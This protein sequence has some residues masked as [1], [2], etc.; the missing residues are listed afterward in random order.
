MRTRRFLFMLTVIALVLA[1]VIPMSGS[2]DRGLPKETPIPIMATQTPTPVVATPTPVSG[3]LERLGYN[4]VPDSQEMEGF[5]REFLDVVDE[6]DTLAANVPLSPGQLSHVKSSLEEARKGIRELTAEQLYMMQSSFEASDVDIQ[7]VKAG[8]EYTKLRVL[9]LAKESGEKDQFPTTSSP[10]SEGSGEKGQ[11]SGP[12]LSSFT[13][14]PT[15]TPVCTPTPPAIPHKN[16][17]QTNAAA[18]DLFPPNW[19]TDIGCP[20]GGYPT[21]VMFGFMIALDALNVGSIILEAMCTEKTIVVG[22]NVQDPIQ[23]VIKS[24]LDYVILAVQTVND[25]FDLCNGMVD[26]ATIQAL[27]EDTKIVHADLAMH[28]GNLHTRFNWTDKFLFNFRN[29]N[30]RL[31]IEANL[32]SPDDEPHALLALPRS[33]CIS[34]ELETLQATDPYAPEV[35]AGCGLLELVRDT[36]R[37]AIDMTITAGE[38]VHDAE[39]EYAAAVVHYNNGEWKLAYTRF[40]N[41]YRDALRL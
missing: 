4:E 40:R 32:A 26:S 20:K 27:Y 21:E 11:G 30:L 12:S 18:G 3:I 34:T 16:H 1:T 9:A 41:A 2:A 15:P 13:S 17:E 6:L 24:V 28:D 7:A 22:L 25:G 31:N 39:A 37:A 29:L 14:I 23:C 5:R 19:P 8:V 36:V 35:I 38:S 33:V 10:T